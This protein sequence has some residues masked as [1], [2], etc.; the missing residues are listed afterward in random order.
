M[1]Y[2][3]ET[4]INLDYQ[5]DIENQSSKFI[6]NLPL[7]GIGRTDVSSDRSSIALLGNNGNG[8]DLY[9][10]NIN[11]YS[12]TCLLK[13]QNTY[14]NFPAFSADGKKII[15]STSLSITALSNFVPGA[16]SSRIRRIF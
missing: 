4:G 2:C 7:D 8:H 5:Y 16:W 11:D 6:T 14:K 3:E 1:Q 13:N 9:L 15:F 12:L 10:F